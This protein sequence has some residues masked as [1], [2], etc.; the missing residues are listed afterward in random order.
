MKGSIDSRSRINFIDK[1]LQAKGDHKFIFIQL[2]KTKRVECANRV[3][4]EVYDCVERVNFVL[5]SI[6]GEATISFIKLL[7]LLSLQIKK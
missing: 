2:L 6:L 5:L 1:Q 4:E 3:T 7:I